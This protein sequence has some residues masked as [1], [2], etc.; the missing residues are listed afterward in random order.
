MA[1]LVSLSIITIIKSYLSLVTR[2]TNRG[3][4]II[5]SIVISFYNMSRTLVN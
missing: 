4:F 3:S 1:Y 5:K 2:L